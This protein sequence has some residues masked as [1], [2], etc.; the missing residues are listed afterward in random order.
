MKRKG[1]SSVQTRT[2]QWLSGAL[3]S[4]LIRCLKDSVCAN[5]K[6][7]QGDYKL[8]K[9][10][11]ICWDAHG[12]RGFIF[13]IRIIKKKLRVFTQNIFFLNLTCRDWTVCF[14]L[15]ITLCFSHTHSHMQPQGSASL[16]VV[17]S[18]RRISWWWKVVLM[19]CLQSS[20][21]ET[22]I[23]SSLWPSLTPGLLSDLIS[24]LLGPKVGWFELL[25]FF[26]LSGRCL[27]LYLV[28]CCCFFSCTACP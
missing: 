12:D 18:I 9:K 10:T 20:T 4:S 27:C 1:R 24:L 15:P 11:G 21:G 26:V 22:D 25:Y 17:G 28:A 2:S 16:Y 23:W 19:W 3:P 14:S 5:V 8:K 7:W 13:G 6:I